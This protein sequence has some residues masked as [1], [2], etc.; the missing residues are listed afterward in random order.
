MCER[1]P[2]HTHCCRFFYLQLGFQQKRQLHVNPHP[3]AVPS[4]Y[5]LLHLESFDCSHRVRR[6][7]GTAPSCSNRLAAPP[8][9][10]LILVESG[11]CFLTTRS[12][13]CCSRG[14]CFAPTLLCTRGNKRLR[15]SLFHAR[16][17][18]RSQRPTNSGM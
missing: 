10:F 12:S 11:G 5:L 16:L 13:S 2:L 1:E 3:L 6:C 4:H 7:H 18:I 8:R 14:C 9:A 15:V 17:L